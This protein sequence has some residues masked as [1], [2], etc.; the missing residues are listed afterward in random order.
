MGDVMC[1]QGEVALRA[2]V[3]ASEV[4]VVAAVDF[5]HVCLCFVHTCTHHFSI[6]VGDHRRRIHVSH[7]ILVEPDFVKVGLAAQSRKER[8]RMN[9]AVNQAKAGVY[10][11]T[12]AA[13]PLIADLSLSNLGL[14]PLQVAV[15][16]LKFI[17]NTFR[18]AKHCRKRADSLMKL[19]EVCLSTC[20]LLEDLL[21]E[22]QK[23]AKRSGNTAATM[24]KALDQAVGAFLACIEDTKKLSTQVQ[25]M[26]FSWLYKGSEMRDKL[27]AQHSALKTANDAC[28]QNLQLM[29]AQAIFDVHRAT[30]SPSQSASQSLNLAA[31]ADA[32]VAQRDAEEERLHQRVEELKEEMEELRGTRLA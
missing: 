12:D 16:A 30:V 21:K 4:V 5:V 10:A 18:N 13:S 29:T 17:I 19:S 11:A 32:K 20:N 22:A 8:E 9:Q 31:A 24:W 7:Q 1:L 26:G 3:A 28:M 6:Q 2:A 15:T 27:T 23:V 25:D 14:D